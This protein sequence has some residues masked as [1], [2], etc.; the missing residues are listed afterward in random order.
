MKPLF[1][2]L[3][4]ARLSDYQ[5]CIHS[6]EVISSTR[7][8]LKCAGLLKF[9]TGCK[10]LMS[11]KLHVPALNDDDFWILSVACPNL[12]EL[13]FVSMPH[14]SWARITD[15]GIF[16]LCSKLTLLKYLRIK[17]PL[18][19]CI[20]DRYLVDIMSLFIIF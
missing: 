20:T 17:L 13:S 8:E 9:L 2:R 7:E 3:K 15:E 12:R 11:L 4:T 6:I 18:D 16:A 5:S 10:N 19:S 14:L 1:T